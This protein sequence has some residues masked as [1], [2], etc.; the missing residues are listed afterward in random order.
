MDKDQNTLK[1]NETKLNGK[2]T[3]DQN[4][5]FQ[6]TNPGDEAD[7]DSFPRVEDGK[8][9]EQT[10]RRKRKRVRVKKVREDIKQQME[11][12]FCD[13]NLR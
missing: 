9:Q 1:S 4:E 2:R 5:N 3:T 10:Q 13:A 12:Y 7:V 11:F 8:G 6:E